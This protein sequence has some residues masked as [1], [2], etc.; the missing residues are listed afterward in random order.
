[1]ERGLVGGGQQ[2]APDRGLTSDNPVKYSI[3]RK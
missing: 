1:M 2:I 3:G